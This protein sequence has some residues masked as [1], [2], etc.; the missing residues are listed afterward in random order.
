MVADRQSVA[1][2]MIV[3][4]HTVPQRVLHEVTRIRAICISTTCLKRLG[5]TSSFNNFYGFFYLMKTRSTKVGEQDLTL[6]FRL[7]VI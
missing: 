7:L 3:T 6:D 1:P 5:L 4:G 2:E